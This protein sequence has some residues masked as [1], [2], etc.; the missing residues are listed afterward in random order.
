MTKEIKLLTNRFL[1]LLIVIALLVITACAPAPTQAYNPTVIL[2][3]ATSIPSTQL[4]VDA[5]TVTST[6][7]NRTTLPHRVE[8]SAMPSIS[9]DQISEVEFIIDNQLTFVERHAPYTFGRDGGYLVTSFL[10]PGEHSFTVHVSAV[11]GRNAETT[12]KA[13]VE[14]PPN[15][16]DNLADTSWTR[17]TTVSDRQKASSH[18]LPP[19]SQWGLDIDSVGWRISYLP[20]DPH[21]NGQLFDI[22]YQS[23]GMVELRPTI[24][25][26]SIPA[27]SICE[28]PD[29]EFL[30]SYKVSEDGKMLT[31]HPIGKDPCGDRVAILEGTWTRNGN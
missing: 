2:P 3:A 5:F 21:R 24:E 16:P 17:E 30:W 23:K 18:E 6:L 10:S 25:R 14:T 26:P 4:S 7:D 20:E 29:P 8:W 31:L 19:A 1:Y 27:G 13:T 28:E 12:V 22:A 9:E 11:N 15:P